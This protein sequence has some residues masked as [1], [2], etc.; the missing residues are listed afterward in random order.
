MEDNNG[1]IALRKKGKLKSLFR[2]Y[3]TSS[4]MLTKLFTSKA[5]YPNNIVIPPVALRYSAYYRNSIL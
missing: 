2:L 4:L 3:N 1:S 5:T